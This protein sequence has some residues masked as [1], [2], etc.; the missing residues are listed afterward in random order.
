MIFMYRVVY[1]IH[2]YIFQVHTTF[3]VKTHTYIHTQIQLCPCIHRLGIC[4]IPQ[5]KKKFEN[6]RNKQF[7]SFKTHAKQEQAV[8]W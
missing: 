5:A 4:S 8:T 3:F 2:S 1:I 7:L 6:S